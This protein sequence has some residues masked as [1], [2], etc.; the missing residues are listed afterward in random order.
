MTVQQSNIERTHVVG[1]ILVLRIFEDIIIYHFI[2]LKCLYMAATKKTYI[3]SSCRDN[4][5]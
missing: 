5:Q 1:V 3:I 2:Q 4:I